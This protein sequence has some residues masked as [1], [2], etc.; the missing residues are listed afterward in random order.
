MEKISS[1]RNLG[2]LRESYSVWTLLLY[3]CCCICKTSWTYSHCTLYVFQH[4]PSPQIF[5]S[6]NICSCSQDSPTFVSISVFE[7][8]CSPSPTRCSK[9]GVK[10]MHVIMVQREASNSFQKSNEKTCHHWSRGLMLTAELWRVFI[11]IAVI[12]LMPVSQQKAENKVE[13]LS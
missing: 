3:L 10:L 7:K 13:F 12:T 4:W 6:G 1:L 2:C 8:I 9:R 5:T 11:F